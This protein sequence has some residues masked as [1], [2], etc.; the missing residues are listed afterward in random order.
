MTLD[1]T[2]TLTSAT[3]LSFAGNSAFGWEGAWLGSNAQ[4]DRI[5]FTTSTG[6][7][8]SGTI[9]IYGSN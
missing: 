7:F 4:I 3:A 9:T 1:N 8:S 5:D 6:T 2:S